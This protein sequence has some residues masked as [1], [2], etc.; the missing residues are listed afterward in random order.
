M[1]THPT[2]QSRP[3][4]RRRLSCCLFFAVLPVAWFAAAP[5]LPER[6]FWFPFWLGAVVRNGTDGQGGISHLF[7]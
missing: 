1:P 4:G 6:V 3:Y 5:V 7:S 2:G